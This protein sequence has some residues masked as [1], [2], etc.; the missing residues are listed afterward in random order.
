MTTDAPVEIEAEA[1]LVTTDVEAI[2]V[3]AI[4]DEQK[5]SEPSTEIQDKPKEEAKKANPAQKRIDELTR[6]RRE[7]ERDRDY[8][9]EQAMKKEP[10]KPVETVVEPVKTLAD[11]DYDEGKYQEH[12]FSKA[13]AE[14]VDEAKKVLKEEQSQQT[15]SRK[16]TEFRGKEADFSKSVDDYHDVVTN[17][18]LSISQPMADVAMEM[19][20]GPEVLYYLGKNPALADE[21]AHLSPLSAARELGRIEAKLSTKESGEKVSK[22]P[23]PAPK[24]AAVEASTKLNPSKGES[25]KMTD[26][27][28]MKKRTKQLMRN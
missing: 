17:P 27:D 23:A 4:E 9:R 21:I 7:A 13:R 18:S 11:F 20:N 16:V 19:E 1:E 15:T 10:E 26:A 22:A 24:I 3:K 6:N 5:S 8:W 12:L 14:A 25:D 2:E 28:W